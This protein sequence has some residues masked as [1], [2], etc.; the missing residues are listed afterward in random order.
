VRTEKLG[1]D[2]VKFEQDKCKQLEFSV[3][4]PCLNE[5]EYIRGA[6][7]SL[8]D[9]DFREKGELIVVDGMSVDK[10]RQIVQDFIKQGYQITLLEN[11]QKTQAYGLNLGIKQARGEYILR[12]DAHCVYPPGYVRDCLRL[13]KETGAEAAGGMMWPEGREGERVQQAIALALRHPVGVGNARWHLGNYRG[14]AEATYVGAFPRRVFEEVGLYDTNC[15]ANQDGELYLRIM[16]AGGKI[17]LDSSIKVIYF[18]R[19]SLGA[20]A[21][22]YWRYGQGRAYT[23]W[24]HKRFSS[25][26]QLAAPVLVVGLVVSLVGGLVGLVGRLGRWFNLGAG[27]SMEIGANVKGNMGQ[28]GGLEAVIK[29]VLGQGNWWLLFLIF[30]FLYVGGLLGA[31]LLS[32]PREKI[33]FRTRLLVAAAWAVMHLCWGVGFI[34]NFSRLVLRSIFKKA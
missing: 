20:L 6:I 5:E 33:G 14:Y 3:V 31:A 26:R 15:R 1:S 4:M 18:P 17:Y 7:E 16:K 32:W 8:L 29:T 9:D 12:A 13:L 2:K 21:R 23:T 34:Y 10:T 25:W 24:K 22:Q 27:R 28:S 19:K 11:P 30:P